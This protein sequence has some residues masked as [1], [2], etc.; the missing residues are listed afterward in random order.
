M[1]QKFDA[2]KWLLFGYIYASTQIISLMN[3]PNL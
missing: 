3:K 2:S 1:T